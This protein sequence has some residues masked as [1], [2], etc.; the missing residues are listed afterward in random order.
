[1]NI[2]KIF[3]YIVKNIFFVVLLM[4]VFVIFLVTLRMNIFRY[5]NFEF[6]KFDLG[7][8][9]Q[10][11]WYVTQGKSLYLTD[12]FGTNLPRW[13][14]SHVDPI[15]YI[16]VPLF[17]LVPHPLTLVISQVGLVLGSALIVFKLAKMHLKSNLA[18]FFLGVSYV[19]YPALGYIN[20]WTGFHGV[21]AAIVFFFLAFYTFELM[22]TQQNYSKKGLALFWVFLIL[23]MTG[24]EQLPLYVVAYGFFI[25]LF[26]LPKNFLL[27]KKD[28]FG[29]WLREIF[30]LQNIKTGIAMMIVG[31]IW[32]YF[33]F[34]VVIPAN[35]YHRIEGFQRFA[36]A[37]QLDTSVVR[38]VENS[39]Y[40]LS[41]Y[42]AF[43][44]T[45]SEVII[46]ILTNP[47][48]LV[49]VA[50]SGDKL[51]NFR[52]TL[53]PVGYLPFA[54]PQIF[55]I[56]FPDFLIN[57]ATSAD[58]VGTSEIINHRISMIIPVLFISV[59][60]AIGYLS[61]F[62]S[63]F[64][65]IKTSYLVSVLSFFVLFTN[66]KTSFDYNNPIYLWLTQ[67]VKKRVTVFARTVDKSLYDSSLEI[68]KV[69]KLPHLETKD[70]EC[71]QICCRC[72]S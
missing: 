21:T 67:A 51:D 18:A 23:T 32:F 43:G 15:L 70:R 63:K 31:F 17:A 55:M 66:L 36:E 49:R 7:N 45:Y 29:L 37:I 8:M 20:S 35:A 59:I 3:D 5:E 38:D 52:Q 58:G 27:P 72:Y 11:V 62:L 16:F 47:R 40:F 22:Y 9:T 25:M 26:R 48:E 1:M 12:Y 42:E 28:F 41:R 19:S 64:T 4:F 60:Y 53:E 56:A 33:A 39:N 54:Y 24:K 46:G 13:A 2:K 65:K 50:F 69:V 71:A 68:G 44:D 57:Y 6:G 34:F 30:K 10:M 61:R 14:M